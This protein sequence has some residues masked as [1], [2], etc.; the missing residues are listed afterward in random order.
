LNLC[1]QF[2]LAP[3]HSGQKI[4]VNVFPAREDLMET[5]GEKNMYSNNDTTTTSMDSAAPRSIAA[6]SAAAAALVAAFV[7]VVA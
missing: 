5:D 2:Q 3:L 7:L 4:V 6:S 1:F